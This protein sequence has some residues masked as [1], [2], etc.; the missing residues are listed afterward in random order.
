[1]CSCCY[2]NYIYNFFQCPC[3]VEGQLLTSIAPMGEGAQSSGY[4][5]A[6]DTDDSISFPIFPMRLN[7]PSFLYIQCDG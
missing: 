7:N 4:T 2:Y 6:C 5:L 1:M 3:K